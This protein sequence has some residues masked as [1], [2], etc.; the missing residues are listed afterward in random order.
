[1]LLLSSAL[2]AQATCPAGE[3][4]GM[5]EIVSEK[6]SPDLNGMDWVFGG[7]SPENIAAEQHSI[8]AVKAWVKHLKN[9]CDK[10]YA[11]MW[12]D[13]YQQ[14]LNEAKE[15]FRTH[16]QQKDLD[17]YERKQTQEAATTAHWRATHQIK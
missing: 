1:M 15:E 5:L 17:E 12:A 6:I 2:L 10:Q 13:V 8:N 11:S 9:P 3:Y 4:R 14:R 7:D 16:A